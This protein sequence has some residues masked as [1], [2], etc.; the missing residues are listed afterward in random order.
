[1]CRRLHYWSIHCTPGAAVNSSRTP[2]ALSHTKHKTSITMQHVLSIILFLGVFLYHALDRFEEFENDSTPFEKKD[3]YQDLGVERNIS[4]EDYDRFIYAWQS[5][6]K[7]KYGTM[8]RAK[9]LRLVDKLIANFM[10]LKMVHT[11][12]FSASSSLDA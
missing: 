10:F 11:I 12:G 3:F 8:T 6:K 9:Y 7:L 2:H 5:L 4:Q 1:M